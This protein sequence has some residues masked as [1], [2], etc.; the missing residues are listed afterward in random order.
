MLRRKALFAFTLASVVTVL[1]LPVAQAQEEMHDAA[2]E[3]QQQTQEEV[4]ERARE[5]L[6]RF[7]NR[8]QP[9]EPADTTESPTDEAFDAGPV[10][11]FTDAQELDKPVDYLPD[12]GFGLSITGIA[13][14]LTTLRHHKRL[15]KHIRKF[16][17]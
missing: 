14:G 3:E 17:T 4:A 2:T 5:L 13:L 10:E 7:T 9:A 12:S 15:S 6:D 11:T 16:T 8:R 1:C